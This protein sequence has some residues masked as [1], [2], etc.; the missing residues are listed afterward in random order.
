MGDIAIQAEVL[1]YAKPWG[2]ESVPG[3]L[4]MDDRI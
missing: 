1:V 2:Q 4:V 3:A